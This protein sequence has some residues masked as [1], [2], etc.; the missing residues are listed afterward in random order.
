MRDLNAV[1]Y[2]PSKP[3]DPTDGMWLSFRNSDARYTHATITATLVTNRW[4]EVNEISAIVD[5]VGK[6]VVT[7]PGDVCT[8]SNVCATPVKP[9]NQIG[10]NAL[11][12]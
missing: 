9:G 5:Q 10:D 4:L 3:D 6:R 11:Q 12:P 1:Q 7:L 8:T 2:E